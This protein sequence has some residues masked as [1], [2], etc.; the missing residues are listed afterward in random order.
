MGNCRHSES[1]DDNPSR[2]PDRRV[3]DAD[4]RVRPSHAT[5]VP[6]D[7]PES[8]VVRGWTAPEVPK[9]VA[10][11]AAR[12]GRAVTSGD[13]DQHS[14]PARLPPG[15]GRGRETA[16]D[17]AR[18]GHARTV[19]S[20]R[21]RS[22]PHRLSQGQGARR[23]RRGASGSSPVDLRPGQAPALGDRPPRRVVGSALA[24]GSDTTGDVR[25]AATAVGS[26]PASPRLPG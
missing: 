25:T 23:R 18:S 3:L 13:P 15:G 14:A 7:R 11:P 16:S 2:R 12:I 17:R 24:E 9:G 21:G 1:F 5:G 8:S 4:Q 20:S 26:S 6:E 10:L 22:R 19:A